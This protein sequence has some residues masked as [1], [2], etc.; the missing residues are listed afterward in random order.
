MFKKNLI[1]AL[2]LIVLAGVCLSQ[3]VR[4]AVWAGK[5]YEGR[6][7]V[8][9]KQI[10]SML[11]MSESTLHPYRGLQ[12]LIVP[13]AGYLYSGQ[14]AAYAYS[15]VQGADYD[16]AVIIGTSHRYG[17]QGC[18]IYLKGGYETP[19]GITQI[20]EEL[21]K[22]LSEAS[23]FGYIPQ[24]HKEEHSIEVQIPFLQKTLPGIK[25]VPIIMGIPSKR[26][27]FRLADAMA[28]TL[29]GKKVLVIAS[30]DMSHFLAKKE[31]NVLDS[32]TIGLIR[33]SSTATLIKK[34]EK[35]ENIMCGGGGVVSALLYCEENESPRIEILRYADSSAGGGPPDRV[36]GYLA[37]AVYSTSAN[38]KFSLTAAEKK[39]LLDLARSAVNRFVRNNEV[40]TYEPQSPVLLTRKGAFVTL[41]KNQL[42]RGCIGYI[43]PVASLYKTVIQ[44]AI[45]AA[46]Q[47]M[48]FEPVSNAEL[49]DLDIEISVL[50]LP[51]K[52]NDPDVITVGK[53][54]LII[55]QGSKKGLLLPQVPIEQKWSRKTFLQH[56]CLKAGL[57]QDAWKSGADIFIFEAIV[58]H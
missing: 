31:A 5:F 11:N 20:D 33:A 17:F 29:P 47:D 40:I 55:S 51:Q 18:S 46:S 15:L 9:E 3:D 23:G 35:R 52:I 56:A 26:T 4:K 58:F 22:K 38:K 45:Y 42:L 2:S 36:V 10:D 53:Y 37:A 49:K 13:H 6:P 32:E 8:L 14:V 24:A 43:E 50:T 57:P 25:I 27:I 30:T 39:E 12:A 34:I 1:A 54:G 41:K 7:Q 44:A 21:A 16:T 48:R 28:E 19:L